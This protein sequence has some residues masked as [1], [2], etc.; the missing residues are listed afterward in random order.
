[1]S[2]TLVRVIVQRP[3]FSILAE[4]S[5]FAST[6]SDGYYGATRQECWAS[7]TLPNLHL[8]KRNG[9]YCYVDLSILS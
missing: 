9:L 2:G 1:M 3:P 4:N 6:N 5:G 8:A 7:R